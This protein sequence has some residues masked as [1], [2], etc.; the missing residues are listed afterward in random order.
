MLFVFIQKASGRL[1][2]AL[3]QKVRFANRFVGKRRAKRKQSRGNKQHRQQHSKKPARRVRHGESSHYLDVPNTTTL[4]RGTAISG[5]P[6]LPS[7]QSG[8]IAFFAFNFQLS[9]S[10]DLHRSVTG[11]VIGCAIAAPVRRDSNKF[12]FSA[13]YHFAGRSASSISINFGSCF[14]PSACLIIVSWSCRK[15]VF[16]NIRNKNTGK[17]GKFHADTKSIRHKSCRTGVTVARLENHSFPLCISSSRIFGKTK[18]I[19]VV[20][21]SPVIRFSN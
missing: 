5:C 16:P 1:I 8:E 18:S 14:N 7:I 2:A 4:P 11:P 6:P 13:K 15:K 3:A 12:A 21:P 10:Y 9:T 17:K 20:T 19:V